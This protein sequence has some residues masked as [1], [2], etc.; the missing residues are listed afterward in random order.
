MALHGYFDG[1]A[2]SAIPHVSK[3]VLQISP[4][5]DMFVIDKSNDHP[6]L[7]P[8]LLQLSI[9]SIL[10]N[11]KTPPINTRSEPCQN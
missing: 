5:Y 6:Y 3:S 8:I 2:Q 4:R 7:K 9:S 10:L 1:V 11:R